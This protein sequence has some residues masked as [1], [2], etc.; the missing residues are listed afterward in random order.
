MF[1]YILAGFLVGLGIS[2]ASAGGR[3]RVSQDN[4]GALTPSSVST[5]SVSASVGKFD[6][7][8]AGT[9]D[10]RG[11][12]GIAGTLRVG[13]TVSVP[14]ETY[15]ILDNVSFTSNIR[16]RLGQTEHTGHFVPAASATYDLGSSSLKFRVGYF[17][18]DISVGG[19]DIHI[20]Q[21]VTGTDDGAG[22]NRAVTVTPTSSFITL[23]CQD[24]NG[25]DVTMSETGA[26]SGS[27]VCITAIGAGGASNFADSA[28]VSELAGA[29]AAGGS[30]GGYDSVCMLYVSDRWVETSRSNN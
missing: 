21:A 4:S 29:F 27:S 15:I 1:K 14:P 5:S 22:T 26:T 19:R 6:A 8:D 12:V 9:G 17:S 20:V 11:N 16:N 28:G 3:P 13:S 30:G 7:L 2:I 25:C 10:F 18:S 24:T 23:D